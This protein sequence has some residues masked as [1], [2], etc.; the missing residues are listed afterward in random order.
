MNKKGLILFSSICLIIILVALPFITACAQP[1]QAPAPSPKAKPIVLKAVG[2]LPTNHGTMKG[3]GM[4]VDMLNEASKGE[5]TIDWL[6]GPEVIPGR[7]Q[8]EAMRTGVVDMI[9]NPTAYY[10]SDLPEGKALNL[11]QIMPWEERERGFNDLM[12]ELHKKIDVYFLG[13]FRFEPGPAFFFFTNKRIES[14]EDYRGMKFRSVATYKPLMDELGI[15]PIAVDLTEIYNAMDRGLV[16]A[17]G[18]TPSTCLRFNLHEVTKYVNTPGFYSPNTSILLSLD[19]WNKL[20]KHLQDLMI[21]TH[22]KAVRGPIYEYYQDAYDKTWQEMIDSGIEVNE[23]PPAEAERFLDV[24]YSSY[25]KSIEEASTP[26][27]VAKLKE[28]LTK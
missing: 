10:A 18:A 11:S 7:E 9:G 4:Y 14:L 1:A 16:D 28:M 15:V 8:M 24:A 13:R 25:W 22:I 20:P 6:G 26:E 2:F 5:L 12:V 21:E 3:F 23:L 19:T 17:W 27:M